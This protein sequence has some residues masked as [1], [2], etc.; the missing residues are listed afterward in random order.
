MTAIVHLDDALG[1]LLCISFGGIGWTQR[2]G[3]AN[4]KQDGCLD[5]GSLPS[6][7]CEWDSQSDSSG[8]IERVIE[9]CRNETLVA[10]DGVWAVHQR[11]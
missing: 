7:E 2:V 1:R 4:S 8:D 9:S 3:L 5:F 11:H 6:R 10:I